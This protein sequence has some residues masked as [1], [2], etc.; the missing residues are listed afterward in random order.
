M[1]GQRRSAPG[2]KAM[3]GL[4][5]NNYEKRNKRSVWT[6]PTKPYAGAHFAVYPEELITPCILSGCPRGGV[7]LDPFA[8]S[9][10][11]GYV[12]KKHGRD[13]ILIELNPDYK[14]L[15]DQRLQQEVL[16]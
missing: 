4:V 16:I 11:T 12:A 8:G 14:K 5:E 1:R 6:V 15:I 3:G 7:V 2:R 13:F 10:T 9:G